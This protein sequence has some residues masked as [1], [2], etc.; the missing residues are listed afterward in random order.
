MKQES[1]NTLQKFSKFFGLHPLVGFG[2]FATDLMLFGVEVGTFEIGW[3]V[4][5]PVAAFLTIPCVL[6]QKYSYKDDWGSAIGKGMLVGVLT[7]IPTAL[8]SAIPFIGGVLGTV[9]LLSPGGGD[10]EE[11]NPPAPP[12]ASEE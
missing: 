10:K 4:S 12:T 1:A 2:M 6:I 7:A 5:V 9:N 11:A 8:P 3:L